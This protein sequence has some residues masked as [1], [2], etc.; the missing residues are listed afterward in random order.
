[1]ASRRKIPRPDKLESKVIH[2]FRRG[3]AEFRIV[4]SDHE[5]GG[6]IAFEQHDKDAMGEPYWRR[7][8]VSRPFDEIDQISEGADKNWMMM[9]VLLQELIRL[10]TWVYGPPKRKRKK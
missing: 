9:R 4:D 2:T 1:M 6:M 7:L 3:T 10:K 8:D 5:C